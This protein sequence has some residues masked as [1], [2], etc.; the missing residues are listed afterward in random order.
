M[1]KRFEADTYFEQTAARS[2]PAARRT[3]FGDTLHQKPR[4]RLFGLDLMVSTRAHVA[5]ELVAMAKAGE[6]TT[7][8][9]INAHCV[10]VAQTNRTYRDVLGRAD[11]LLP[12]GSGMTI[13]ARLAGTALGENLNGT[14]LFP[15]L[16][17]CAAERGQSI[18]LL[19]GKPGI[20]AAAAEAMQ[21]RYPDLQ[22]AGTRHGYRSANEEDQVV[23]EINASGA[24]IVLVGLGVPTQEIWID[25]IR[26]RLM[27]RVV[28]GVGG[29]FDY[30]SGSIPRAPLALRKA[31]CE[32]LWRLAQEPRRLFAR[33]VLGN[34]RFLA[35]AVIHGWQA[36]D[37]SG[38]ASLALKHG[39]DR[40]TAGM[41]LLLLAP[42]F[43][44]VGAAIRLEDGGPVFF[45]QTRIGT[46]GRP[47]RM[48]KF[49]SMVVDAE[50]RLAAI[51]EQSE[52][53]GTCFKMKRDPRLTRVGAVL[54]RLSL[55][56]LPQLINIAAGDMSVVGPRPALPREVIGYPAEA[57]AR[58]MGK[59]G[60]TCTWQVS[61]R[62][63][64]PFERQVELDVSY[65]RTRSLLADLALILRTVPAVITAR[66]AY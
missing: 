31:G 45:R 20:A 3:P 14:D 18:F 11:F 16:C 17:R 9:F 62:A 8:Q 64:I 51:R 54:R 23:A 58:L 19:G 7:V 39:M 33:Y 42:L 66:G 10:N 53:D 49:R 32:W 6:C 41:A 56:E 55:D 65:L 4:T 50:A 27:A 21:E 26:D 5:E 46:E 60:L 29:L 2:H 59:P 52:R 28:M 47:F 15:E 30:Y 13:A 63:N 40:I 25:R 61:G 35:A 57:R 34:P 37:L 1:L 43:V 44:L 48:W 24:A 36:R 12:D 38:R 22:V